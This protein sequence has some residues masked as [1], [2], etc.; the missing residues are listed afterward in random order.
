M[1]INIFKKGT[2]KLNS[3]IETWIVEWTRRYGVFSDDTEQCYQA[4][5]SKEEAEEFAESI[6][7]AN[8]LIGNTSR[9]KVTVKKQ[10][11]G[12]EEEM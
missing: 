4:F 6:R 11:S 7:R 3:G 5:T 9:T 10:S 8:K 1:N 2:K 12:L